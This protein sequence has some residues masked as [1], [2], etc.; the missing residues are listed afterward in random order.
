M[1]PVTGEPLTETKD[2]TECYCHQDKPYLILFLSIHVLIYIPT[3]LFRIF[4]LHSRVSLEI[5]I[6]PACGWSQHYFLYRTKHVFNS[7]F[8]I[9]VDKV[10][11]L[12]VI[13]AF[14]QTEFPRNLR[15]PTPAFLK[16]TLFHNPDNERLLEIQPNTKSYF[17]ILPFC[18]PQYD[19]LFLNYVNDY[20]IFTAYD[21]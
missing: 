8:I 3:R 9:R 21:N 15:P 6:R 19:F 5:D 12:V 16:M 1:S 14:K 11:H 7:T 4:V 20:H 17:L 2:F 18:S 10:M 13:I